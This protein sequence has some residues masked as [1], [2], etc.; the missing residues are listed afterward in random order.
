MV[1]FI[2]LL[3]A[4]GAADVIPR[5][6]IRRTATRMPLKQRSSCASQ[7]R[8]VRVGRT[9][10]PGDAVVAAVRAPR[11]LVPAKTRPRELRRAVRD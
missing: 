5:F 11:L 6:G 1:E 10:S 8:Q 3:G 7:K 9:S 2:G 4:A